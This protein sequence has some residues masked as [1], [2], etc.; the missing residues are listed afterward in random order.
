MMMEVTSNLGEFGDSIKRAI[1]KMP[2]NID[3]QV[4]NPIVYAAAVEWG[5]V[6]SSGSWVP[7]V[8]MM[9]KAVEEALPDLRFQYNQVM[10]KGFDPENWGREF[11]NAT[12][13]VSYSTSLRLY[14]YTP[15]LT[16]DLAGNW[17]VSVRTSE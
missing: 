3:I 5:H 1:R 15:K 9:Q 11:I 10:A 13:R 17:K 8:F 12:R 16:G 4:T 7:G 2:R 6:T 14:S